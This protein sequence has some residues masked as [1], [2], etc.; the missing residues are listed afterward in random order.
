MEQGNL[1]GES[2]YCNGCGIMIHLNPPFGSPDT[3]RAQVD[4][5]VPVSRPWLW[6]GDIDDLWNLQALCG[7]CNREKYDKTEKE[8][9]MTKPNYWVEHYVNRRNMQLQNRKAW[10]SNA[11]HRRTVYGW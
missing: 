8:W 11:D 2:G 3:Y 5:I 6:N 9:M 10:M 7:N 1:G 4:H